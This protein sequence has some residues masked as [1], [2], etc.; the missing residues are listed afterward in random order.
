MASSLAVVS[1]GLCA[2][3]ALTAGVGRVLRSRVTDARQSNRFVPVVRVG[4]GDAGEYVEFPVRSFAAHPGVLGVTTPRGSRLV[5]GPPETHFELV[6]RPVLAGDSAS[7]RRERR[8]RLSGYLGETPSDHGLA[9]QDVELEGQAMWQVPGREPGQASVWAIHVH[10]LGSRRSQT[11][12]SVETFANLGIPSLVPTYRTSLDG[13]T[14]PPRSHLGLTEWQQVA[15]A[16]EYAVAAGAEKII[17]VGWSLGASIVLQTIQRVPCPAV[18]GALLVSPALD[19]RAITL[20][21]LNEARVPRGLARW[22][23]SGFNLARPSGDPHV[24][25][26]ELPGTSMT[27]DPQVPV[28][29]FHGAADASVPIRLSRDLAERQ[30]RV[31]L[32]EFPGAHHTLEWNSDPALWDREIRAWCA[33]LDL[34]IGTPADTVNDLERHTS[35][36][37]PKAQ[38]REISGPLRP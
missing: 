24:P 8:G 4:A 3:W 33:A 32:V 29:L 5:L 9:Y 27:T 19:W 17:F 35:W 38:Q 12:R 18:R 34:P 31:R 6:R 11:L 25:W 22:A 14:A 20:A 36:Q 23:M 1:G 16:Q 37:Q 21:A 10:G 26:A 13:Q 7:L 15:R 28:L 2:Y 30:P